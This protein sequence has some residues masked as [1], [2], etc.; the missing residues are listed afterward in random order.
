MI[1]VA[2]QANTTEV[3]VIASITDSNGL[4]ATTL[5]FNPPSIVLVGSPTVEP[6]F[7]LWV[8]VCERRHRCHIVQVGCLD[9]RTNSQIVIVAK[10]HLNYTEKLT[11]VVPRA[12]RLVPGAWLLRS[13]RP[14]LN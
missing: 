13:Q 5:S 6:G 11:I 14:K 2:I 1:Q 10:T 3:N 12:S 8:K 4:R 7:D 9:H